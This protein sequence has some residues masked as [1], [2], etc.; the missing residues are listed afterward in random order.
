[1][2]HAMGQKLISI[3]R[4]AMVAAQGVTSG[5]PMMVGSRLL[6]GWLTA[7]GIPWV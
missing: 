3:R 4:L 5:T 6:Q 2:V 1:M 7:S